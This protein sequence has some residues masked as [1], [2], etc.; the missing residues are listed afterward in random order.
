MGSIIVPRVL[1]EWQKSI[2]N[3]ARLG[4]RKLLLYT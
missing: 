4:I 1:S 2:W 3:L